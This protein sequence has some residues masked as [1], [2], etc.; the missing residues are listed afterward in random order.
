MKAIIKRE[1]KNFFKNPIFWIGLVIMT[2]GI[3]QFLEPY[4]NLHYFKSDQ[5]IQSIVVANRDDADVMDGYIPSSAETKREAGYKEL[6][7]E[8][9]D[10][11]GLPEQEVDM[12]INTIR[13][14]SVSEACQYLESEYGYYGA[15][16]FL[17]GSGYEQGSAQEVSAFLEEKMKEHTFSYYFA[18]KFADFTG[19][20][21]SFFATILLAFLFLRDTRKNTYELLHTKPITAWQ[22]VIGKTAGGFCSLAAALGILTVVF[23]ILCA[24]HGKMEGFS[25]NTGD[26]IFAACVYILPNMLM[27]VCVYAI[28]ALIFK[29]PLPATPLLFL[30]IV[31][32]NMG[33]VGTDGQYGYHGRALS[34]LVRFPG[35]FFDTELPP[36]LFLNQTFLVLASI[37]FIALAV[38]TWKR[39]R[40]Y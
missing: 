11:M 13:E 33:S 38:Y 24:V 30:Y 32:S 15:A 31:Y 5:E 16:Y 39:R 19:L 7:S 26:M 22:Y 17:D 21:M 36:M 9:V 27:I 8:M 34:I 12:V 2:A 29:N 25:V 40:V 28:I 14:M 23:S 3:Y 4:L 35:K 20:F 1:M 10:Q 18:R 6:R 37:L